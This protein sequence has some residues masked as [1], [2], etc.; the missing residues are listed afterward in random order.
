MRIGV[1][2]GGGDCPE[3]NAAIRAVVARAANYGP[4]VYAIES[5]WTG[6]IEG[7]IKPLSVGDVQY[8]IDQGGTIIHTSRT[9]PYS[10][11]R[12]AEGA[13]RKV[14]ENVR[15]HRIDA[16]VAIGGDDTLL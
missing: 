3:L 1:L 16:I 11:K 9:N 14:Y 10:P 4:E 6:A 8:I 15:K 2:T 5:G 13:P 7:R 12:L